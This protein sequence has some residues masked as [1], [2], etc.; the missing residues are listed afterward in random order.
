MVRARAM[1]SW[2][3]LLLVLMSN[4]FQMMVSA[5]ESE[6]YQTRGIKVDI[7]GTDTAGKG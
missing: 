5:T 4:S 2:I 1:A 3:L 7:G 6:A